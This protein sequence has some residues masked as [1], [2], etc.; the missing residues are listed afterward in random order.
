MAPKSPFSNGALWV[1]PGCPDH[2][3]DGTHER[4]YVT[5]GCG[6]GGDLDRTLVVMRRRRRRRRRPG[7]SK[8]VELQKWDLGEIKTKNTR[9]CKGN[10]GPEPREAVKWS[11]SM[12]K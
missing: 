1:V 5:P 10:F 6:R 2:V 7:G 12:L 11:V 8:E 3:S 4:V 9:H